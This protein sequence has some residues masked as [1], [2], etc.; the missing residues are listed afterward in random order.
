MAIMLATKLHILSLFL[1]I[2][3]RVTEHDEI[4]MDIIGLQDVLMMSL[5]YL[6]TE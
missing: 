5:M 3:L 6:D 1:D 4:K 2:I